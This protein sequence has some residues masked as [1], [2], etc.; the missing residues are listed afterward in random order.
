[1]MDMPLPVQSPDEVLRFDPLQP[2]SLEH[3]L[4]CGQAF[5]WEYADGWWQG[6]VASTPLKV[7]QEGNTLRYRGGDRAFM[8]RY[9]SLDI[10]LREILRKITKDPVI[11]EAVDRCRGLRILRQ[12]PWECLA[13]YIGATFSSIPMVRRRV[14]LLSERF[15]E[16]L[17]FEDTT[18]YGFP[19]PERIAQASLDELGC[20]KMGYRARYLRSTAQKIVLDPG[21]EERI[22]ALP[23]HEARRAMQEFDGVGRKAAD[24][25]L[26]FAFQKYESFPVDV[27]IHRIMQKHYGQGGPKPLT[28]TGYDQIGAFAREHFGKFAGYAQEYLYCARKDDPA[29]IRSLSPSSACRRPGPD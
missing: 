16:P 9:F 2:F 17:S 24:C 7:R 21:W 23:Y 27:W 5:R 25:V 4:S 8:E 11:G 29:G 20:C 15:G 22:R 13:S 19:P 6:I 1:M 18:A 3:T 14:A 10:D 26:L 12:P 28:N